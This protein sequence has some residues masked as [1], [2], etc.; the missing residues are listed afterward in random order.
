MQELLNKGIEFLSS[1]QQKNGSF[2][3]LS[4][5]DPDNFTQAHT[6]HSIFSTALILSCLSDITEIPAL[7]E[8]KQNAAS[9]L[10]KQKSNAW[11]FN[12]WQRKSEESKTMPYPDDLDDTF[13]ALS[14]LH[15]YNPKL[16]DGKIFAKIISMLTAMEVEEGG[17]YRTWLVNNDAPAIWKDVDIA[18]NSNIAYF[19]SRQEI[20]LPKL[21]AFIENAIKTNTLVSPYYHTDFPILYFISR[22]YKGANSEKLSDLLNAKSTNGVW[23]NALQNAFAIST[24]LELKIPSRN[25]TKSVEVLIKHQ[26]DGVWDASGFYIDPMQHGKK[27]YAGSRELTTTFCIY[28][29]YKYQQT[30]AIETKRPIADSVGKNNQNVHTLVL[31]KVG[32]RFIHFDNA[33]KQETEKVLMKIL[34]ADIAKQIT[35]LPYY[36]AQSIHVERKTIPLPLCVQ[37]G[38]ASV[39]GWIAYT[40]Y[41]DF[42]DDEG[43]KT[44][45]PIANIALRELTTLFLTT[46]SKEP[47]FINLFRTT[48]DKL[49]QANYWE[50]SHC[51]VVIQD[52]ILQFT[53]FQIP[54]YEDYSKLAERSM[55]HALAPAA[56]LMYVGY[57]AKSPEVKSLLK[58]FRY[59]IIARQLN[60]DAHD[61]EEDIKRGHVNAVGSL[62]LATLQKKMKKIPSDITKLIPKMHELFWKEIVVQICEDILKHIKIARKVIH[63]NPVITDTTIFEEMLAPVEASATKALEEHAKVTKFL[64]SYSED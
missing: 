51:R 50:V 35:L 37:L 38:A 1:Q 31:E 21:D 7:E 11:S 23:Q 29:L 46:L 34:N 3:S 36:V 63:K 16:F 44:T 49:E 61:F 6:F 58:F 28:A 26:N 2:L 60:D 9:F 13:C 20:S 15:A 52:G 14:A 30:Q 48:M 17:P 25:L 41:D 45:L 55:G 8:I 4:S 62:I 59:Y 54:D 22:F 64:A 12:Y 27:Y 42:L 57:G 40:F 39:F 18:V 5:A 10:L 24:L 32:Q 53:K 56:I 43:V 47:S 19:L 33:T